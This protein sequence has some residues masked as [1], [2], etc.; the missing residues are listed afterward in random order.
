MTLTYFC[1]IPNLGIMFF[2]A[3]SQTWHLFN[4]IIESLKRDEIRSKQR[5]RWTYGIASAASGLLVV[6][7]KNMGT[8]SQEMV[9]YRR[10]H[11]HLRAFLLTYSWLALCLLFAYSLLT[12]DLLLTLSLFTKK[13]ASLLS[14]E[15]VSPTYE[16]SSPTSDVCDGASNSTLFPNPAEDEKILGRG[17]STV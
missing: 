12:L 8:Q 16:L 2:S 10:E 14:V 17:D 6:F 3:S 11:K 4:E 15:K 9:V 5:A 7:V 13:E 1:T